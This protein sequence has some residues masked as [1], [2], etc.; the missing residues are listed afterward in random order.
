MSVAATN[1]HMLALQANGG[2]SVLLSAGAGREATPVA[3]RAVADGAVS[4]VPSRGGS[5]LIA[6]GAQ[7][8]HYTL[9]SAF[10]H[11]EP[12]PATRQVYIV[13]PEGGKV[14]RVSYGYASQAGHH[15][16]S[17][18][19]VNQDSLL[20]AEC[21][22][23]MEQCVQHSIALWA[24]FDGHGPRGE[25]ASVRCSCV[26][27]P[28][29]PLSDPPRAAPSQHFCRHHLAATVTSDSRG[30]TKTFRSDPVRALREAFPRLHR[31]LVAAAQASAVAGASSA[32]AS[33]GRGGAGG[34]AASGGDSVILPSGTPTV[35]SGVV[36]GSGVLKTGF[37]PW[38]SV[39]TDVSGCTANAVM[40]VGGNLLCGN[41]G[42]SRSILVSR[43]QRGAAPAAGGG[44][45]NPHLGTVRVAALS[46]DH[47]PGRAEERA[48][49]S[50]TDAQIISE[51]MLLP[52]GD[53]DKLYVCRK[54][55]SSIKYGVLFS[56]SIGDLDS[57]T[58]LGLTAE[59]EVRTHTLQPD[60]DQFVVLAA[61]AE[62]QGGGRGGTPSYRLHADAQRAAED[63]V[64]S[65]TRKWDRAAMGRQD[66]ITVQ[67]LA[68]TWMSPAEAEADAAAW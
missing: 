66:D 17:G 63:V 27:P 64:A 28:A 48:R 11:P 32:S 1:K 45:A 16:S 52:H 46:K 22:G 62:A 37:T 13:Q 60:S 18:E 25:D 53:P 44:S 23:G 39:D 36:S 4:H 5:Y 47:K 35:G 49:I 43:A 20:A 31:H 33:I 42:D 57:H 9:G 8:E 15:Q 54:V 29:L 58:H 7:E 6:F 2:G 40:V 68:F 41:V 21:L 3:P 10:Q 14:L 38:R 51:S 56:R 55:G 19:K 30:R 61:R 12:L 65:A 59:A 50:R 24:V 26:A 34:P 67:V